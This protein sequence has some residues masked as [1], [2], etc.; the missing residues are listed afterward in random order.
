MATGDE[1]ILTG[2]Y[3][4]FA[5]ESRYDFSTVDEH[6]VSKVLGAVSDAIELFSF[7]FAGVDIKKIEDYAKANGEG[8]QAVVNFLKSRPQAEIKSELEKAIPN[9]DLMP[10]AESCFLNRLMKSAKVSFRMGDSIA[11][12][13]TKPEKEAS[14]DQI[15]FIGRFEKWI[16]I[17]KLTLEKAQEWEISAV[18]A[19]INYTSVNKAFDF[20]GMERNEAL[21]LKLSSGKRKSFSTL[22]LVV[23]QM[24]SELSGDRMKDAYVI[25]KVLENTGYR[26]YANPEMLVKAYPGVKPPKPK[27]RMPK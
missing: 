8:F 7:K 18:L 14:G 1:L 2:V 25:C 4:D 16:T 12:P 11:V 10:A 19:G 27:G 15:I 23:E 6:E 5:V 24:L 17:K 26:P 22:V 3:K 20:S 21:I 13:S 9:K